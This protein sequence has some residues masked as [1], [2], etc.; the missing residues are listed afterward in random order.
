[1]ATGRSGT[2]RAQLE[3]AARGEPPPADGAVETLP[4]P[5]GP[6]MAIVAFTGHHVVASSAPEDW[7]RAQL[8]PGDLRAPMSARFVNALADRVG[9]R[10]DSVDVVLAAPGLGGAAALTECA[11]DAHPRVERAHAHREDV[12]VFEDA[13]GHAVV[14]LGRGLARR[15]EVAIEVDDAH[16]GRGLARAAL[17]EARRLV[18]PGE[19]LFAQTAPGNAASLLALLAAGFRPIGGEVLLFTERPTAKYP[20]GV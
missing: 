7:V 14:I 10:P 20:R 3:A 1:M 19:A 15:T 18:A 8:P 4:A 2:L 13:S 16:R 11:R 6:A 17:S 5:P 12:R 9:A